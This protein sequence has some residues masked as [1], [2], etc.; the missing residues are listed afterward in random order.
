[1]LL[2][3]AVSEWFEGVLVCPLGH[4]VS[5]APGVQHDVVMHVWA[6]T[7]Q[8][9]VPCKATLGNARMINGLAGVM[10]TLGV[11]RGPEATGPRRLFA[12]PAM[13]DA[14]RDVR[15]PA[16]RQI[17]NVIFGIGWDGVLVVEAGSDA[18]G[19]G[20]SLKSSVSAKCFGA[21]F[22]RIRPPFP[23]GAFLSCLLFVLVQI[24]PP[25]ACHNCCLQQAKQAL[26]LDVCPWAE[27]QHHVAVAAKFPH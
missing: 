26:R 8:L 4:F 27:P 13:H 18:R 11:L 21:R 19:W 14:T 16:G 6:V 15:P 22:F 20:E 5:L 1:M 9:K 12:N 17:A 25:L 7:A 24:I 10:F 3:Q 23:L 2:I